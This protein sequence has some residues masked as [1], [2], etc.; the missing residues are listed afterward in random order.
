MKYL[1]PLLIFVFLL[2]SGCGPEKT[3]ELKKAPV[4]SEKLIEQ[5]N[6]YFDVLPTSADNPDNLTTDSKIILGQTL[7][8]DKQLSKDQTQSCNTCHNMTTYGVDN[9]PTS[10]GDNGG[11]GTRNAPTVL[12]SALHFSQFWDGREPDVEAQAGGPVLNPVEMA[13]PSEA[14]MIKRLKKDKNYR[15]MF[16]LA[17]PDV[18]D[19]ITYENMRKAIGTYERQLLTPSPFDKFLAGVKDAL[20]E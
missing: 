7:F 2:T 11:F 6:I 5:A 20:N 10:K 1:I 17:F 12:N 13:I 4:N 16:A 8:F 9:L 15:E 3:P 14:F 18:A 19:P